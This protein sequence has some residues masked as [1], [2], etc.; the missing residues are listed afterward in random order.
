MKRTEEGIPDKHQ[1]RRHDC[2][3][4]DSEQR[5]NWR[6]SNR[7]V[8]WRMAFPGLCR[9][10]AVQGTKL[11]RPVRVSPGNEEDFLIGEEDDDG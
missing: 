7:R 6:R 3:G 2:D 4:R 1:R 11:R 10:L 8:S 9:A 5:R